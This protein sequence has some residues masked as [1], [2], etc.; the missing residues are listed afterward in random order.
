MTGVEVIAA[1]AR[2][3]SKPSGQN[4]IVRVTSSDDNSGVGR[5]QISSSP[6]FSTFTEFA[7]TGSVTDIPWTLGVAGQVYVRVTD[8]AGNV[9]SVVSDK[10]YAVYLPLLMR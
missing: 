9:S 1:L 5:I 2:R 6:D 10:F 4:V 3:P 8:R 7:P